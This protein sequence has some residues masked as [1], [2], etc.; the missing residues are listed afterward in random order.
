MRVQQLRL[1]VVH[2]T[3]NSIRAEKNLRLALTE[4]SSDPTVC[5]PEIIDVVNNAGL[6]LGDGVIVTPTLVGRRGASRQIILGD[7]SD[8]DRLRLFLRSLFA[9]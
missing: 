9:V 7:L 8:M 6:A 1:Y 2:G 3:P 4:I 5:E